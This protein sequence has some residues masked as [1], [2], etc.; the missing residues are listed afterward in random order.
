MGCRAMCVR[1]TAPSTRVSNV[2]APARRGRASNAVLT[3]LETAHPVRA[4]KI[5]SEPER[6]F[7]VGSCRCSHSCPLSACVHT[8]PAAVSMDSATTMTPSSQHLQPSKAV[9]A[10]RA[11]ALPLDSVVGSRVRSLAFARPLNQAH[12]CIRSLQSLF[13]VRFALSTRQHRT[14][15]T[16][17]SPA[18]CADVDAGCVGA[19]KDQV[20]VR[21]VLPTFGSSARNETPEPHR[22]VVSSLESPELFHLAASKEFACTPISQCEATHA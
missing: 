11:L 2:V 21:R 3:A 14:N 5:P 19:Y 13:S 10:V 9:T 16:V 12:A 15:N 20:E 4:V 18:Q 7:R 17:R 6:S 22:G 1:P 8:Q